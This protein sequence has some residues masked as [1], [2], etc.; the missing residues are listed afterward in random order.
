M[1]PCRAPGRCLPGCTTSHSLTCDRTPTSIETYTYLRGVQAETWQQFQTA[2]RVPA[3][4]TVEVALGSDDPNWQAD[5]D[6]LRLAH[7]DGLIVQE[8]HT[9]AYG[10]PLPGLS[11][12]VG[13]RRY[14]YGYQGQYA[15]QDP[16]TGLESFE[17]RLYNDR[18]GRWT[19]YD[20]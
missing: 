18:I 10:R 9:Y 5:C 6:D 17:L 15:E 19:S 13:T 11:Y 16:E 4:G 14:R 8:Q 3:P 2:L 7:A 1:N 20:P 12:A